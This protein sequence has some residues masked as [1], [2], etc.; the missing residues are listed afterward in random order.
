MKNNPFNEIMNFEVERKDYVKLCRCKSKKYT[1]YSDWNRHITDCIQKITD[2]DKLENFKRYCICQK[3]TMSSAPGLIG[4]YVVLLIN[5]FINI[6]SHIISSTNIFIIFFD[7]SI[8]LFVFYSI[9]NHK[10]A[11]CESA[12]FEDILEVIEEIQNK[13]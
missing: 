4:I 2:P 12:F 6:F 11:I 13:K 8:I 1:Y 10:K 3:R 7:V 9:I 5:I